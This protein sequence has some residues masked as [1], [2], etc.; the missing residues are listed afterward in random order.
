MKRCLIT[1]IGG[2]L[3]SHLAEL[4]LEKGF[5]VYGTCRQDTAAVEHIRDRLTLLPCELQEREQVEAAIAHAQPEVVYHLAAQSV[6]SLSWREPALTFLVNQMGTFHLLEALRR[7]APAATVVMVGSSAEYGDSGRL[8]LPLRE[9]QPLLPLSPYGVSKVAADLLAR[10]YARIYGLRVIRA[11]PFFITG[12][13]KTQDVCS[14]FA[15]G[16]VAVERGE[17]TSLRVGNLEP[18]RDF[19]DVRDGTRALFLLAE[20]GMPEEVYNICSGVGR[21]VRAVLEILLSLA[22]RPIP[23]EPDPSRLRPADEPVVVGDSSKLRALGWEPQV[24]LEETLRSML[25]YWRAAAG[26]PAAAPGPASPSTRRH[27]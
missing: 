17:Q 20:R 25:D 14:D 11:R 6:P 3:G 7:S 16:I 1:G 8:R 21:P 24:P 26:R 12:P 13:R 5:A 27:R 15:R 4:L 23:V 2:F 19:L 22:T 9:D 10:L 18:V